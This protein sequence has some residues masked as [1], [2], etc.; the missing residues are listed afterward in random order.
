MRT[1]AFGREWS[2]G[3]AR[4]RNTVGLVWIRLGAGWHFR[5]VF[6][7]FGGIHFA[8]FAAPTIGDTKSE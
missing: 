6:G 3:V 4:D 1:I 7:Q 2:V 5:L 8:W